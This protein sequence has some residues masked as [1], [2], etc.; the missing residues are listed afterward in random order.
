MSSQRAGCPAEWTDL[1]SSQTTDEEVC[2]PLARR[3]TSD[4]SEAAQSPTNAALIEA[5]RAADA[6]L[7]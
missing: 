7:Y 5:L 4:K 2:E 3:D 6:A 1:S